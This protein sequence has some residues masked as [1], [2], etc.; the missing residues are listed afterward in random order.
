M[1]TT[2]AVQAWLRQRFAAGEITGRTRTLL[3]AR[4]A[5]FVR[6]YGPRPVADIGRAEVRRWSQQVGRLSAATRRQYLST[7]HC[8]LQWCVAED[9]TDD[10]ASRHLARI[11][12]PRRAPRARTR[13]DVAQIYAVCTTR[14]DRAI[15][16]LMVQ[17]GLRACEIAR[18]EVA[19]WDV[20]AGTLLV[21]GKGGHERVLPVTARAATELTA[22]RESLA[23]PTAFGSLICDRITGRHPIA[24]STVSRVVSRLL[25][26]AGVK[27]AGGDGVTPHALRH[28]AASDVLDRCGNVRTVQA[29]L[30]HQNLNTT[31]IYLR[32]ASL[33]QLR[34]AMEG[35]DYSLA[36]GRDPTVAGAGSPR[37]GAPSPGVVS[38]EAGDPTEGPDP[39]ITDHKEQPCPDCDLMSARR[40]GS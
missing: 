5:E 23:A 37:R 27:R 17:L 35:R 12:E 26:A 30:G 3:E 10:D 20:T 32:R 36:G 11:R 29:M 8:F 21:R 14:R 9:H 22:Y 6:M 19:D 15:V 33:Q 34:E 39:D 4:L 1:S 24:P 28:T 13:E 18:L 2:E 40:T 16:C 38:P 7:L 25:R 31:A